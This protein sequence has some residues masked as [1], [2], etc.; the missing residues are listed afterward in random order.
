MQNAGQKSRV[1]LMQRADAMAVLTLGAAAI[2]AIPASE[3]PWKVALALLGLGSVG[4]LFLGLHRRITAYLVDRGLYG[5]GT[6]LAIIQPLCF[7]VLL[8]LYAGLGQF[9]LSIAAPLPL[10]MTFS[11]AVCGAAA[12]GNA[13]VLIINA[14]ALFRGI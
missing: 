8:G 6:A 12:L 9:G 2:A 13:L 14:T 5:F 11:I 7:F 3:G 4:A 10:P 1:R